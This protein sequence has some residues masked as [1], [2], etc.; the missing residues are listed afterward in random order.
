[1]SSRKEGLLRFSHVRFAYKYVFDLG[2]A[3]DPLDAARRLLDHDVGVAAVG[4]DPADVY[5]A[6]RFATIGRSV[7]DLSAL[8]EA[9]ARLSRGIWA[10]LRFI[11]LRPRLALWTVQALVAARRGQSGSEEPPSTGL[12]ETIDELSRAMLEVPML[13]Q[14]EVAMDRRRLSPGYL[15]S[16]P[17]CRVELQPVFGRVGGLEI[18]LDAHLLVHRTG[19]CVLTFWWQH[20]RSLSTDALIKAVHP[21]SRTFDRVSIVADV[22]RAAAKAW[23]ADVSPPQDRSEINGV[24]FWGYETDDEPIALGPSFEVYADA[25]RSHVLGGDLVRSQLRN[26]DWFCFPVTF[27]TARRVATFDKLSPDQQAQIGGIATGHEA[28]RTAPQERLQAWLGEDWSLRP[29]Q[30]VHFSSASMVVLSAGGTRTHADADDLEWSGLT[31]YM[32]QRYWSARTVD[33]MALGVA[34]NPLSMQKVT[35]QFL[36]ASIELFGPPDTS[37]GTA[38]E[39]VERADVNFGVPDLI[40]S[41]RERVALT[42]DAVTA[43]VEQRQAR[44]DVVLQF[45]AAAAAVVLGLPAIDDLVQ[46][47]V[48]VR[49]PEWAVDLLDPIRRHPELS[50]ALC[51]LALSLAVV[52]V[53]FWALRRPPGGAPLAERAHRPFTGRFPYRW[54]GDPVE[55]RL[56]G[57]G[58]EPRE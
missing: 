36:L 38:N 13:Q 21:S 37:W 7:A 46:R 39:M 33:Q 12:A 9:N 34:P 18:E 14:I 32:L 25:L 43:Q 16:L 23:R 2:A 19:T 5:I 49:S 3:V 56:E 31:D 6:R 45:V 54:P 11:A 28:W 24:A 4:L 52:L 26:G 29:D 48:M 35:E 27:A 47:L 30:A 17:Y 10:Y 41:A 58:T 51:W 40:T 53:L 15:S 44:R 1:M 8:Q 55:V 22:V 50:T 20:E 42:R 57:S